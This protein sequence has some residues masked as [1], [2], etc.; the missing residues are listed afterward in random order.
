[1]ISEKLQM[2]KNDESIEI[3]CFYFSSF[4]FL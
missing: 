4:F 1:M 3:I 2:V